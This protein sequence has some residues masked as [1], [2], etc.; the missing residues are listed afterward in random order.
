MY[1]TCTHLISVHPWLLFSRKR[2]MLSSIFMCLSNFNMH[3]DQDNPK[4]LA[5]TANESEGRSTK[6]IFTYFLQ[7]VIVF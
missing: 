4:P 6:N 5:T 2:Y 3:N 7:P 1:P